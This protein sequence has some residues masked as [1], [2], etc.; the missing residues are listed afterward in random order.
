MSKDVLSISDKEQFYTKLLDRVRAGLGLPEAL[1]KEAQVKELSEIQQAAEVMQNEGIEE[2]IK[3]L[4]VSERDKNTLLH[5]HKTGRE[6]EILDELSVIY[7]WWIDKQSKIVWPLLW[8]S[9]T[10]FVA[11]FAIGVILWLLMGL[12]AGIT[13]GSIWC[14]MIVAIYFKI[15]TT[16]TSLVKGT[17]GGNSWI[18]S[19]P[20]FR[21]LTNSLKNTIAFRQA[22]MLYGSGILMSDIIKSLHPIYQNHSSVISEVSTK[23]EHQGMSFRDLEEKCTWWEQEDLERL[24]VAEDSGTLEDAFGNLARK[25]GNIL[26]R[27]IDRLPKIFAGVGLLIGGIVTITL[28]VYFWIFY[29]L[30]IIRDRIPG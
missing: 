18:S 11:G 24:Q 12:T 29:Y 9:F 7:R 5:G 28:V 26:E 19:L 6:E 8:Y 25:H 3:Y 27:R 10:L 14:S 22:E 17:D 1:K 30:P 2:G 20:V 21:S 4:P 15:K 16:L 13:A 23:I